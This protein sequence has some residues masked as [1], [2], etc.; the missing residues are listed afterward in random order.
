MVYAIGSFV[1][2]W[3]LSQHDDVPDPYKVH[4]R[5]INDLMD[6]HPLVETMHGHN[7]YP[8]VHLGVETGF[9]EE[10]GATPVQD[11]IQALTVKPENLKDFAELVK[12]FDADTT[13]SQ[14]L[15][16]AIAS[17]PP[18]HFLVWTHS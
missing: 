14:G 17:N 18:S 4:R 3:D 2:G 8:I 5:E 6:E 10:Y 11:V 16:D 15:K 7:H 9:V 13:I 1:Y 12:D